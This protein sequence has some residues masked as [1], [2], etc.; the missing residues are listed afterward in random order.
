MGFIVSVLVLLAL[1]R[2]SSSRPSN[3]G[4]VARDPHLANHPIEPVENGV[5]TLFGSED[6]GETKRSLYKILQSRKHRP[7]VPRRRTAP[8]PE[9]LS[10]RRRSLF[11]IIRDKYKKDDEQPKKR[12]I[13][14]T[15]DKERSLKDVVERLEKE[16]AEKDKRSDRS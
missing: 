12:K 2:T 5:Y 8:K 6:S 15:D 4:D 10:D 16:K 11:N 14:K 9:S 13:K 1:I 7:A 3:T